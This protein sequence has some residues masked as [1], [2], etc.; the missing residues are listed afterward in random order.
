MP[1]PSEEHRSKG[2]RRRKPGARSVIRLRALS[3]PFLFSAVAYS[4]SALK[5]GR[6]SL[7]YLLLQEGV[8]SFVS[9]SVTLNLPPPPELMV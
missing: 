8:S 9:L 3:V 7:Y 6:T 4:E 5:G 1:H 2:Q